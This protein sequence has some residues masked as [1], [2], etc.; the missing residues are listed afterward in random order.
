M[1]AV[2]MDGPEREGISNQRTDIGFPGVQ[3]KRATVVDIM[4]G[5]EQEL[6]FAAEGGRTVLRGMPIK[7]YP[8]FVKIS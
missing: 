2:W 3:G 6:D 7:D 8:I 1:V 5:T 4:N